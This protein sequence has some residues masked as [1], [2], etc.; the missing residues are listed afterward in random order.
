MTRLSLQ[1]LH[2]HPSLCPHRAWGLVRQLAACQVINW[3]EKTYYNIFGSQIKLIKLAI[4]S[5]EGLSKESVIELFNGVQAKYPE[6]LGA[7]DIDQYLK[8]LL[9]SNLIEVKD[10]Q[11]H[12]TKRGAEFIKILSGSGYIEDKNL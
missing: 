7:W 5:K 10:D 6:I 12:A 11:Y 9:V 2:F 4:S 8:Y 1:L 3:F